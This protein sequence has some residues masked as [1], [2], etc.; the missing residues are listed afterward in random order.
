MTAM[1]LSRK[2]IKNFRELIFSWWK[3]H[4]R[5]LPWRH[6]HDP[7]KIM[8]SEV[9]LQQTQVA[10]VLPKYGEFIERYPSVHDL[11]KALTSDV[12][13]TWKGMGYNRRALYL[14]QAA[15]RIVK[16]YRGKFPK[17]EKELVKLLGLGT[18]TARA[19]L[20]FAYRQEVACVD[21]NIRQIITHFFFKDK[22]Q[23]PSIIQLVAD[24]LV[25][26]GKAW[27]WHQA[28]MD[29]GSEE[30]KTLNL[31]MKNEKK[32]AIPFRE[33]DRFYR[34]RII[35]RLRE[36]NIRESVILKEFQTKYGKSRE[37]TRTILSGLENDGLL[38]RFAIGV[39]GLPRG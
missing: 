2:K 4:H 36:G 27:E 16:E 18:Y 26:K 32:K 7:Y 24:Q 22:L 12:L 21:T 38:A 35:D 17:S 13:K 28:L 31:K 15:Q 1:K 3:D 23:K 19:I 37:F 39:I 14:K 9:M 5:D 29:Y 20:V 25:P 34:G 6:T 10:R 30:L 8:V 33:S 11:A